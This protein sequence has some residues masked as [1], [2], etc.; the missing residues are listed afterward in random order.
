[1]ASSV[2][3]RLNL[4][5]QS[6]IL[7]VGAPPSFE[8]ALAALHGIAIVRDPARAGPVDFALAFATRRDQVDALAKV[9]VKKATDDAVIW[10]AYPKGTSKRLKSEINRDQGW[11]EL[12]AAGFDTVRLIAIDEDWSALRFRR[13][14]RIGKPKARRPAR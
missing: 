12:R 10:F 1:M 7:V 14:E 2:F 8:A 4:K 13:M 9:L 5:D 3:E 6:E 11:D